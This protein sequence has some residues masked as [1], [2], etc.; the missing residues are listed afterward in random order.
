MTFMDCVRVLAGCIWEIMQIH[1]PG[2]QISFLQLAVA[3]AFF[4]V[5]INV[6]ARIFGGTIGVDT[7]IRTG[8]QIKRLND[9][10]KEESDE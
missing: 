1:I 5:L 2:T 4:P 7:A 3:L 6:F 10:R 9:E 8:V